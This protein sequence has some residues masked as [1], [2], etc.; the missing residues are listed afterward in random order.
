MVERSPQERHRRRIYF[1]IMIPCLTLIITAWTIVQFFSTTAAVAMSVVAMVM[2]P[3]AAIMA[4]A[5][6][7]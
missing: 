5:G 3:I 6:S 7:D 2:P 1:A 4:N